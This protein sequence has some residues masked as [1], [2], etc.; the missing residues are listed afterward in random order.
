MLEFKTS[1]F[2]VHPLYIMKNCSIVG[3]GLDLQSMTAGGILLSIKSEVVFSAS[4][5]ACV[6]SSVDSMA[7]LA[8]VAAEYINSPPT[9]QL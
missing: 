9:V 6:D 2:L 3:L 7:V 4:T 1:R 8:A 5:E